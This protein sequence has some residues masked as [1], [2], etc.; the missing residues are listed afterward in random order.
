MISTKG[1]N[2]SNRLQTWFTY[3]VHQVSGAKSMLA[4]FDVLVS[5]VRCIPFT[6][7]LYGNRISGKGP[8]RPPTGLFAL[9]PELAI[10]LVITVGGQADEVVAFG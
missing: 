4:V 6:I 2:T 10:Y 1:N 7:I 5:P 3:T 9:P 8:L